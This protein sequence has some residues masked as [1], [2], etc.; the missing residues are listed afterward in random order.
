MKT[1]ERLDFLDF[2]RVFATFMVLILHC[3]CDYFNNVANSSSALWTV[4]GFVNELC[5]TGVPLFFMI[6]GYLL[7]RK[8]ITD[9]KSFYKKRFLKIAIPFVVYDIFYFIFNCLIYKTPISVL[10]FFRELFNNGSSYHFWFVYSI[11][12]IYLLMPFLRM[13]VSKCNLKLMLLFLALSVFQ[14]TIRPFINT[15]CSESFYVFLTDDGIM[16]YIGYV[17]WGYILGSYRFSKKTNA[18]ILALGLISFIAFPL[19]SMQNARLK[20]ALMFNGG[21]FI[22]HYIEGAALF[23]FFRGVAKKGNRFVSALSAVSFTA[24]LI[25]VAVIEVVKK[26]ETG[27]SPSLDMLFMAT[28]TIVLSFLWG[29]I[30]SFIK[31]GFRALKKKTVN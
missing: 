27:L 20:G 11:L 5:R 2:I 25:H 23:L 3:I 13:I 17:I 7:L 12:F 14:T 15:L 21:Y 24:Y 19:I 8:D 29:F 30:E 4:L 10:T 9:I 6:S 16:G 26:L 31:K 28:V 18:V 1:E 22:N